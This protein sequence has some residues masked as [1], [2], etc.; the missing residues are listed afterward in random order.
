MRLMKE[1]KPNIVF[2]A[3]ALKHVPI[4][5]RDWSEGVKTNIFG[6]VNVADAALAGPRATAVLLAGLPL[7]GLAMGA[8][9]GADP[10]ALLGQPS[11]ALFVLAPGLLLEAG[12]LLWITRITRRAAMW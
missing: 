10:I 4:L 12:G 9:L 1:F 11:V 6:S 7:A 8:S 5:E 2:H 3:A